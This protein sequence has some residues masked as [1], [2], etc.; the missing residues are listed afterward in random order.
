MKTTENKSNL[1]WLTTGL[2]VHLVKLVIKAY[3]SLNDDREFRLG[4]LAP[5]LPLD[6]VLSVKFLWQTKSDHGMGLSTGMPSSAVFTFELALA[7]VWTGQL[8]LFQILPKAQFWGQHMLRR[9]FSKNLGCNHPVWGREVVCTSLWRKGGHASGSQDLRRQP[10]ALELGSLTTVSAK[11][12]SF[13]ESHSNFF[14]FKSIWDGSYHL[15][16]ILL[17]CSLVL[18]WNVWDLGSITSSAQPQGI[19]NQ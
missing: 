12:C 7:W 15:Y 13:K 10:Q 19:Q 5:L 14:F 2:P 1:V 3:I 9:V 8:I 11:I 17:F 4:F 16:K 6:T 18:T